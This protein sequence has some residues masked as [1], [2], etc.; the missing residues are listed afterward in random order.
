[1][2]LVLL[3]LGGLAARPAAAQGSGTE[4]TSY[5]F[6]SPGE[7]CVGQYSTALIQG[8]N[9]QIYGTTQIGGTNGY[10]TV[11]SYDGSAV[12]EGLTTLYNFCTTASCGDGSSPTGGVIQGGDGNFYGMTPSGG[13]GGMGTIFQMTPD[14]TLTT[15]YSFCAANS[16]CPDGSSPGALIE[17]SDGN[18]YGTTNQGGVGNH[19][20]V[21]KLTPAGVFTTI[22]SFC[23]AGGT[24]CPD[25][26]GPTSNLIEGSDGNFYGI[27]SAGD[28]T[29]Y[30]I[31]SSGTLTTVY[32]FCGT[33]DTSCANGAIPSGLV[34]ASGGNF[35]GT[36]NGAGA[37][38]AG[39][40][41][42]LTPSGA[43][44]V[45]YNF[46][47]TTDPN[48]NNGYGP[49][50]LVLDSD[51]NLYGVAGGGVNYGG[52]LF[53]V[54]PAGV[55]TLMSA[56]CAGFG[57]LPP[58]C[59]FNGTYPDSLSLMGDGW[60]MGSTT[61][62]S[63]ARAYEEFGGTIFTGG[64][65]TKPPAALQ[66]SFPA[67]RVKVGETTTLSWQAV[68]AFSL[69]SQ[70]CY[71]FAVPATGGGN[72]TGK[73]TGTLSGNVFSGQSAITPT[74]AGTYTYEMTCGGGVSASTTL[75]VGSPPVITTTSLPTGLQYTPYSQALAVSGGTA[76]YKWSI[77]QG[78]LPPGLSLNASTGVISGVPTVVSSL[79][80]TFTVQVTDSEN[81]PASGTAAISI[82][83]DYAQAAV[84]VTASPSLNISYGQA[85]TINATEAPILTSAEGFSWSVVDGNTTLAPDIPMNAAGTMTYTIPALSLPVG[86]QFIAVFVNQAGNPDGFVGDSGVQIT[87]GKATSTTALATSG[88]MIDL[89]T[90]V[91]LTATVAS[92][93][94]GMPTGSVEFMNGA[95]VLGTVSL[96]NGA[97]ALTTSA[98][99][100]GVEDVRAVYSGD[101]NFVTSSSAP[102][103]VTVRPLPVVTTAGLANGVLNASYA[104]TLGVSGGVAPYAW[105]VTNGQL[106]AGL[107]LNAATGAISGT[108][109]A[110]GTADFTVTVKDSAATPMTATASLSIAV[111]QPALLVKAA[112][113]PVT[114]VIYGQTVSLSASET[115]VLTA[116]EGYVWNLSDGSTVLASNVAA[117]A[118]GTFSYSVPSI[119]VGQHS[120]VLTF[121]NP[122]DANLAGKAT[123]PLNVGK[124]PTTTTLALSGATANQ[125]ASVNLTATVASSAG[126]PTG[127]VEFMDGTTMLGTVNLSGDA[128]SFST[129]ALPA[130]TDSITAVYSGDGN[131]VAS[132]ST[133]M[134]VVVTAP[135]FSLAAS[136]TSL[137]I[138]DGA[139][140]T[141]KI[142]MTTVGGYSGMVQLACSGLPKYTTCS[143]SPASLTANGQN[144]MISST[145]TIATDVGTGA[146]SEQAPLAVAGMVAGVLF[147]FRRRW[148][149]RMILVVVC[150]VAALA[151]VSGCGGGGSGGSTSNTTPPG[152]YA[153]TVSVTPSGGSAKQL[154]L[155][156]TI[157]Q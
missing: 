21:F 147:A 7:I 111:N 60:M 142:A 100:T 112:A 4:G 40:V 114:G 49:G 78:Q 144:G 18:F 31:T 70:Q 123:I 96:T 106:P 124:A 66:L 51:G 8:A 116:A 108:P 58:S 131:F 27:T 15:L 84:G 117:N 136:P 61:T 23:S 35:Y 152:T 89:G 133:A 33:S 57:P 140:G 137:S 54:T 34:E 62:N 157:T 10:G 68:N 47:G 130:G 86:S 120:F 110:L 101:G 141:A 113:S 148:R 67:A 91:T 90:S 83:V 75:T 39:T 156:V 73:Q 151:A 138:A 3:L 139:T 30:R 53:Q 43:L 50:G 48:C 92:T 16:A 24:T 63:F 153:V 127:S 9:G 17:G 45:L 126:M 121:S 69:T 74:V 36:A 14:G 32:Q 132:T 77:T 79:P 103:P 94:S 88:A 22:Y 95:T 80:T 59:G 11:F 85:L 98:L 44:T 134:A 97:A 107:S 76:P 46:C 99:P 143:F 93:T 38:G 154:A 19:G 119:A 115:P 29:I 72:W 37:G 42:S 105:S 82:S 2:P 129:T 128:A 87:V 28:G 125:G 25:G 6:C 145:L 55:G 104:Q 109:A 65:A 71:A 1:M 118:S 56:F 102:L 149:L 64:P 150:A 122:A 135:D 155:N 13:A 81:A 146:M 5:L 41:F 26:S 52:T 20:T 12:L